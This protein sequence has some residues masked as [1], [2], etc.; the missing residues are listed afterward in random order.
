MLKITTIIGLRLDLYSFSHL[1]NPD[2]SIQI[3]GALAVCKAMLVGMV[4]LSSRVSKFFFAT[5]STRT[6]QCNTPLS[7]LMPCL[8]FLFFFEYSQQLMDLV[9][10]LQEKLIEEKRKMQTLEVKIREEVCQ[11]MAEQL[12]SIEKAYR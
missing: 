3:S 6:L 11:E 4:D 8:T 7:T 12:V 5:I 1:P 9:K 2:W 10:V